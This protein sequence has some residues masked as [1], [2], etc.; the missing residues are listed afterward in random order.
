[1]SFNLMRA[2]AV[3]EA[4]SAKLEEENAAKQNAL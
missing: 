3:G 4:A 2:A 1:M